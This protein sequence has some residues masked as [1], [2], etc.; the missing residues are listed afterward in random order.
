MLNVDIA[1]S[2]EPKR[3]FLTAVLLTLLY[4]IT[5]ADTLGSH[6]LPVRREVGLCSCCGA[7]PT[8][9]SLTSLWRTVSIY[10]DQG[11]R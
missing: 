1:V 8:P 9:P 2:R 7:T 4:R 3:R 11:I 6:D 5:T 10:H